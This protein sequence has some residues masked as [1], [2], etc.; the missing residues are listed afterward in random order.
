MDIPQGFDATKQYVA[1]LRITQGYRPGGTSLNFNPGCVVKMAPLDQQL[2]VDQGTV[3]LPAAATDPL[4]VGLV[5]EDWQGFTGAPP[6]SYVGSA[7]QLTLRGSQMVKVTVNGY[8]AAASIDNSATAATNIVNGTPLG[9]STNTPAAGN[10]A[11]LAAAA[12]GQ[13]GYAMLPAAGIGSSLTHGTG[14]VVTAA[15]QTATI[16]GTPTLGDVYTTT[17]SVPYLGSP[18]YTQSPGIAQTLAF[19]APALTSTTAAS[20]TTAAAATVTY[21]NAQA[22]F[23]TF[24]SAANVAGVITIT[25]LPAQFFV[26]YALGGGFY[27]TTS[28]SVGNSLTLACAVSGV[29]TYTAGGGNFAAGAGYKGTCPMLIQGGQTI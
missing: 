14:G 2:W 8:H 12:V 18:N 24:Y 22:I 20:V 21:L 16:A 13:I 25:V 10:L 1:F 28:G 17:V 27:I 4:C 5:S 3:I 15:S 6:Q 9:I 23:S 11:G 19:V 29:S 26:S 7:N